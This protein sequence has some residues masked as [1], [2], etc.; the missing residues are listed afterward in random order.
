MNRAINPILVLGSPRSGTSVLAGCLR[1]LGANLG[2]NL[3]TVRGFGRS[4]DCKQNSDVIRIHDIL[5]RDLGCR[6][7][8]IGALPINWPK[9]EAAAAA[10]EK[11][12]NLIDREFS[13]H[14]LWAV[15]EPRLCGFLPLWLNVLFERGLSPAVVLMVRNPHEVA[16]ALKEDNGFDL[17]KGHILWLSANF[18]AMSHL[19]NSGYAI[20]T[21]DRLFADPVSS[22]EALAQHVN[23]HYPQNLS[24]ARE[25]LIAFIKSTMKQAHIP[26]K[27]L[28]QKQGDAFSHYA[29]IY[30][31]FRIHQSRPLAASNGHP[32]DGPTSFSAAVAGKAPFLFPTAPGEGKPGHITEIFSRTTKILDDFLELIAPYE[33]AEIDF[34][35]RR[36]RRLLEAGHQEPLL[37]AELLV[38]VLQGK[39]QVSYP[40]DNLK[41]VLLAPEEWQTVSIDMPAPE[42]LRQSR[43]RFDPLNTRGII[44]IQSMAL[45]NAVTDEPLWTMPGSA[46]FEECIIEGRALELDRQKR[47]VLCAMKNGIRLFLPLFPGLPDAPLRFQARLKAGRDLDRLSR[48]WNLTRRRLEQT[49]IR[50]KQTLSE[51]ERMIQEREAIEEQLEDQVKAVHEKEAI[52]RDLKEEKSELET[53]KQKMS[54]ELEEK[55]R[56]AASN[57]ERLQALQGSLSSQENLTKQYFTELHKSE[58]Q[59]AEVR[60]QAERL[61]A[62]NRESA[63]LIDQLDKDLDAL[64]FS[65]RWRLGNL[66]VRM[67]EIL[68]LRKKQPLA[69]DHMQ[70]VLKRLGRL[71]GVQDKTAGSAIQ[72]PSESRSQAYQE[73]DARTLNIWLQQLH[74]DLESL[75]GSMRWR[76]GNAVI[77][78]IELM[79]LRRR[80]SLA[81][82]HLEQM[83]RQYANQSAQYPVQNVGQLKAWLNQAND[84]FRAVRDSMRWRVGNSVFAV[85]DALLLRWNKS[86][87][88]DHALKILDEY[89]EWKKRA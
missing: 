66:L 56:E 77:R 39:G 41:K 65:A 1:L 79:A 33:Q 35:A 36:Q 72:Q 48:E 55:A 80:Q 46:G 37:Y 78:T 64:V 76:L 71:Q 30:D 20:F 16:C 53:R 83:F 47:L 50:V 86:T 57:V 17:L 73:H 2:Q 21:L 61:E 11:I 84:D 60:Q 14:W 40:H 31:Q 67:V 51:N 29:W 28:G 58:T 88:M 87:A 52:I 5:M 4:Q 12:G 19:R 27:F 70:E 8:M 42:S 59:L 75:R 81:M 43:L 89:E 82:D 63:V 38:P 13:A 85:I 23:L 54:R 44:E 3:E 10:R 74:N 49:E 22:L 68:M 45:I 32:S 6:W 18:Q 7:D 15:A 24:E 25:D 26:K 62:R 9:S 69:I 34:E